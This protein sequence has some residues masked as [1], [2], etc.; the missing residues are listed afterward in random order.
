MILDSVDLRWAVQRL[1]K[2]LAETMQLK[3]WEN[4]IF[5]GGGYLR[6]MNVTVSCYWGKV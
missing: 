4:K 6:S 5:V 2:R 3:D 1:P